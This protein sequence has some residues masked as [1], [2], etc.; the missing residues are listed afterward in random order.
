MTAM[1]TSKKDAH[2]VVEAG[3]KGYETRD[4]NPS[5][6]FVVGGG[7]IVLILVVMFI[8]L[9]ILKI[10]Q[11]DRPTT[12]EPPPPATAEA[13][14]VPPEPRLQTN[15]EADY[16][17]LLV[18]QDSVLRS[19]GWMDEHLG[20]ARIPIDTAI[21]IVAAQD[22]PF[23]PQPPAVQENSQPGTGRNQE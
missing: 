14:V 12:G 16:A 6:L 19:Y 22:L 3:G 4:A 23:R 7:L 15:P 18:E 20:I 8:V 2:P 10:F 9:G 13:H 11:S 21:A 1:K 5:M 17:R